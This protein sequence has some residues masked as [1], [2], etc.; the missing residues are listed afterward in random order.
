MKS[1][2]QQSQLTERVCLQVECDVAFS[3]YYAADGHHQ[4]AEDDMSARYPLLQ[5][6]GTED[7]GD[8]WPVAL[9]YAV[10]RTV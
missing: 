5:E 6:Y 10:N 4:D 8:Q 2:H 9:Y 7:H 3:S 1:E